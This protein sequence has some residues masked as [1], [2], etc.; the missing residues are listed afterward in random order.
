MHIC[1]GRIFVREVFYRVPAVFSGDEIRFK[2]TNR[3]DSFVAFFINVHVVLQY[4]ANGRMAWSTSTQGS[5]G[6][7]R[8]RR[9]IVSAAYLI[10]S[11][12][13]GYNCLDFGKLPDHQPHAVD[14]VMTLLE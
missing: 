13:L 12:L 7:N 4:S 3:P 1:R 9:P 11:S 5:N 14:E 6:S 8:F 2:E 10:G